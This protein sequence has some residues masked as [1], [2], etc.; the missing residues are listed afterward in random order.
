MKYFAEILMST[1][2]VAVVVF[3]ILL[4]NTDPY[5]IEQE[6]SVVPEF[7]R[8][9]LETKFQDSIDLINANRFYSYMKNVRLLGTRPKQVELPNPYAY[10]NIIYQLESKCRDSSFVD[11]GNKEKILMYKCKRYKY[12]LGVKKFESSKFATIRKEVEEINKKSCN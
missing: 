4:S 6:V 10:G 9:E 11:Y 1:I 7:K 8:I 2:I 5:A 3:L 12:L